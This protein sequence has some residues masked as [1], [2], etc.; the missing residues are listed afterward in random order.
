MSFFFAT[1]ASFVKYQ[2]LDSAGK[3]VLESRIEDDPPAAVLSPGLKPR[4]RIAFDSPEA[5]EA[6]QWMHRFRWAPWVRDPKTGEIRDLT[7]E[8]A[9]TTPGVIRGVVRPV[10]TQDDKD[11]LNLLS[12][13]RLALMSF[14]LN[15][16]TWLLQDVSLGICPFPPLKAGDPSPAPLLPLT[17]GLNRLLVNHPD[18]F[19]AAEQWLAFETGT[20]ASRIVNQMYSDNGFT[21]MISTWELHHAGLDNLLPLVPPQWLAAETYSFSGQNVVPYINGWTAVDQE[22]D[23]GVIKPMLD[24]PTFDYDKALTRVAVTANDK[25]LGLA[26]PE[27]QKFRTNWSIV[28]LVVVTIALALGGREVF[29]SQ[30]RQARV[31]AAAASSLV[32]GTKQSR[33]MFF[34]CL[35]LGPAL[36]LLLVFAYYPVA[37]GSVMAFQDYHLSGHSDFVGLK[38]F[39]EGLFASRFWLAAFNTLIWVV[40]NLGMGFL[41]PFLLAIL[42][43]ELPIGTVTFRTIYYL[44]AVTAGLVVTLLW[45]RLYDPTEAGILNVFVHPLFSLWNDL[46]PAAWHA[47]WPIN[48]LQSPG[49]AMIAVIVPGIWGGAGPGALIYLAALKSIPEEM[50]EAADLDGCGPWSKFTQSLFRPFFRCS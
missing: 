7:E 14:D 19:A 24:S 25:V 4:F 50:Y 16:K 12:R 2:W 21:R 46:T 43:S 49:W 35:L 38:N 45:M 39:S 1:G 17:M 29:K 23:S 8:E 42:V 28:V 18:K 15:S 32:P 37:R 30:I 40:L 6:L 44:P 36:L 9:L 10:V 22:L 20:Q 31:A 11:S 47:P 33:V 27:T 13:G 48:W 3:V 41:A 26:T 5:R 34:S